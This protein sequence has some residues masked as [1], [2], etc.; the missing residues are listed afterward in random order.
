MSEPVITKRCS[1]CK[2]IKPLSEFSK[3]TCN[4]DGL[5]Y[6]CKIC[7]QAWTRRYKTTQNYR[8]SLQKS[9]AK[10][11][12]KEKRKIY[13]KSENGLVAHRK[14]S[15]VYNSRNPAKRKAHDKVN[16]EI[17][18][19]RLEKPT[20]FKCVYCD[21]QAEQYHHHNGYDENHW[22]DIIPVCKICHI[23]IHKTNR[24]KSQV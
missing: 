10:P 9:Y 1:H 17:R 14:G 23:K 6:A 21:S 15:M 19:G 8:I 13:Q 2:E 20:T 4:K 18:S 22:F 11:D 7:E 5:R 24:Q 16:G 12:Y 3:H